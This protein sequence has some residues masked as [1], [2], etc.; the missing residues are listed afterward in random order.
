MI[1]WNIWLGSTV[2]D[3]SQLC[4]LERAEF[5]DCLWDQ[6]VLYES[7]ELNGKISIE[8]LFDNWDINIDWI[9]SNLIMDDL[10]FAFGHGEW[11]DSL[12]KKRIKIYY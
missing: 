1:L 5:I 7:G 3:E 11:P 6:W 4:T 2:V 8:K 12:N 9:E 10:I